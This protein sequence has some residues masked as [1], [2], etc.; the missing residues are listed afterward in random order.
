MNIHGVRNSFINIGAS[1]VSRPWFGGM[2]FQKGAYFIG[3]GVHPLSGVGG[4]LA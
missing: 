4:A 3:K 1:R 2:R